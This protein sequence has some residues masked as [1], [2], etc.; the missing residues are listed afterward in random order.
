MQYALVVHY[1]HEKFLQEINQK[2][3]EGWQPQG[4]VIVYSDRHPEKDMYSCNYFAQALIQLPEQMA[5]DFLAH[6][7]FEKAM[8]LA[9][10]KAQRYRQL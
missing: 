9:V 8:T 2:L 6:A 1:D 4:G 5:S 10:K 3:S 7:G